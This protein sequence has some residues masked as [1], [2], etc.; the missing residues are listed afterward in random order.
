MAIDT[1]ENVVTLLAVIV[2]LLYTLFNYIK[3]PRR[4]WFLLS[5]FFLTHLLSDYYWTTYTLVMGDNPDVS[6]MMAYFGWNMAYLFL[7]FLSIEMRPDNAKDYFHPLMLIPIPLG[8]IQFFMYIQYGGI[9]NNLWEGTLVT[10]TSVYSLQ[11]I[12][13]YMH[14][15]K[16]GM[17]FP[18]LHVCL[19]LLDI[20]EYGMWTSSCFS[21]PSPALNPY[22]YFSFANAFTMAIL[23]IAA[24]RSYEGE[25]RLYEGAGH[26]VTEISPQETRFTVLLQATVSIIIFFG[27]F[28]GYYV[29]FK[30]KQL[31][32]V[33]GSGD[34]TYEKIAVTLFVISLFLV[35]FIL[36]I[37]IMTAL[38]YKSIDSNLP[39]E[40]AIKRSRFNFI[41]TIIIT[42]CLM[43]TSVIYTSRLFYDVSVR[44]ALEDGRTRVYST[45]VELE[46]YLTLATS[47]LLVVS[48]SVELMLRTHQSQEYIRNYIID[49]TVCQ[50]HQFADDLTGFY[51]YINGEYMDGIGWVP[52]SGYDAQQRDWYKAAVD[53]DG[54]ITIVPPYVDAQSKKIV[55]TICKLLDDRGEPGDYND[56]KVVA[57]DLILNY[58]QDVTGDMSIGGKGYAF[59][60]NSDG[61]IIAHHDQKLNGQNAND[62]YGTEFMDAVRSNVGGSL[63]TTM[64]GYKNT[65]F[66]EMVMDQ[67]YVVVA[68]SNSQ[69]YEDTYRQ[70]AVNL[71]V[72]LV[73]FL[74]IT[75]FYFLAHKMEQLNAQKIEDMRSDSL[76]Q[77]Y[78]AESLKQREAATDEANRAR[79]KFLSELA[80]GVV[81]PVSD[82]LNT[83]KKILR[84]SDDPETIECAREVNS[85]GSSL[86]EL[87]NTISDFS[88]IENGRISIIPSGFDTVSFV[89]N[90]ADSISPQ[91]IYKGL[92]FV[93]D[94]DESLPT[95]L[96]G[97]DKRLSQVISNL[98]TNAVKYTEK[99]TVTL[100]IKK[101]FS[102]DE[103]IR[104]H[105]EVKDTGIGIRPDDIGHLALSFDGSGDIRNKNIHGTGLGMSV[106]TS[107]LGLMNSTI[108]VESTFGQGSVF[109]FNVD[110][111]IMDETPIGSFHYP[112]G[113]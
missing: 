60:V 69:L 40:A 65:I 28:G 39:V 45:S 26:T 48:D 44:G 105:V 103:R 49:Q 98:L 21:W 71:I 10:L 64:N 96:Y 84:H 66:P 25:M 17:P 67:W 15:K 23:G 104:I 14:S 8:I 92:S 2:G 90:L 56:R 80:E 68:I 102:M 11:V 83:N 106:V 95:M 27:C 73:I 7:F 35:A 101:D 86:L 72:S 112:P 1:V 9:F 42:F 99:G 20:F 53:A 5:F 82:L 6:A 94:I 30:M 93:L 75:F 81:T 91:A 70:L 34:M 87:I 55:I 100:S 46:N 24:A 108:N 88:K 79:S 33:D 89:T 63:E 77:S 38:H 43:S 12:L 59:V 97:D 3:K 61:L 22:Y 16:D 85:T 37:I 18:Y 36:V 52:P 78:E 57:M 41:F 76:K 109:Y 31:I 58:I 19:L 51:A 4:G 29:G 74:L 62:L 111:E 47:T 50:K 13:K 54:S 113:S 32:P 107:L 110:L